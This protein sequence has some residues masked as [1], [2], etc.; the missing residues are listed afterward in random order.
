MVMTK[1]TT[2]SAWLLVLSSKMYPKNIQCML[3]NDRT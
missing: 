1:P 3:N 2:P